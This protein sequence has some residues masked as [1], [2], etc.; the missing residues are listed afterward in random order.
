MSWRS[1]YR[2][3]GSVHAEPFGPPPPWREFPRRP[4]GLKFQP[5]R[6][7]TD[8]VNAALSLRRPLLV[9]GM[10]GSG[11]STI[12]ESVAEELTL[13][14]VLRWHITS[15]S[16]LA[17]ALYRYDVLGRINEQQLRQGVPGSAAVDISPY[18]QLGPLGT[19]FL[20]GS[21]P[22][23]LLI[24]EIDKSDLDLPSDLLDVLERGEFEIPELTRYADP[25]VTVR[26]WDP[27]AM[28]PISRGR[29][30]CSEFPFIV[31]TS[32]E[33]RDFPAA[34][35]R[36]CVR[37]SM[38]PP[39]EEDIRNIVRAHLDLLIPADGALADLVAGFVTRLQAGESLAIDQLLSAV[40]VLAGPDAPDGQHRDDLA[41]LLLRELTRA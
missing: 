1:Y 19:A 28:A 35:L 8:A 5:P 10:P 16:N 41:R 22:R 31:L 7:L 34:F 12:I 13:G 27:D 18:L 15:R 39:S 26:T 17:D 23:A 4:L 30:R 33:E 9:T 20:P 32:N 38:P 21:R 37:F 6:G 29:V 36:R 2:G 25:E 40:F 3:D 14:P 24:D 11:K